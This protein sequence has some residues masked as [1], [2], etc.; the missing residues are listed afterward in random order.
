MRNGC[1]FY[2]SSLLL[3]QLWHV[4]MFVPAKYIIHQNLWKLLVQRPISRFGVALDEFYVNVGG[5]KCEL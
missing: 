3:A 1:F 2:V 5:E 4:S